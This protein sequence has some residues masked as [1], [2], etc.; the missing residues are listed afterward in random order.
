MFY[1][2][3]NKKKKKKKTWASDVGLKTIRKT[4]LVTND[5]ACP[6]SNQLHSTEQVTFK[7]SLPGGKG[8]R[9]REEYSR[10][11]TLQM[12]NPV[13]RMC[14]M[15]RVARSPVWLW[16]HQD[17]KAGQKG[18]LALPVNKGWH[19]RIM[20]R[21]GTPWGWIHHSGQWWNLILFHPVWTSVRH[22]YQ[23]NTCWCE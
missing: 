23:R 14:G 20:S 8:A 18:S 12:Q 2:D 15:L 10:Q 5:R 16:L 3:V 21:E 13:V 6:P 7:Q 4:K 19:R 1:K 11:S 17:D 22:A 9:Y